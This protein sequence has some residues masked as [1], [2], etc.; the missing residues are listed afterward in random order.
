MWW[1]IKPSQKTWMVFDQLTMLINDDDEHWKSTNSL[2]YLS[3]FVP[4][5]PLP[6][7]LAIYSVRS[8]FCTQSWKICVYMCPKKNITVQLPQ[9][10]WNVD[11]CNDNS[12]LSK[13]TEKGRVSCDLSIPLCLIKVASNVW[14]KKNREK[15]DIAQFYY[16]C[17]AMCKRAHFPFTFPMVWDLNQPHEANPRLPERAHFP[18]QIPAN[19]NE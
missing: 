9:K 16:L 19:A 5:L 8:V 17:F 11:N 7:R 14:T 15:S 12:K 3:L 1:L 2:S 18:L 6:W 13:K 4:F 10:L